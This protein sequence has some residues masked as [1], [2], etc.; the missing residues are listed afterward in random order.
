M[1]I[2]GDCLKLPG[3]DKEKEEEEVEAAPGSPGD[4]DKTGDAQKTEGADNDAQI[5]Q[6]VIKTEKIV[7]DLGIKGAKA[8]S[9]D[10]EAIPNE[11][12]KQEK[13]DTVD[14]D[15]MEVEN[16]DNRAEKRKKYRTAWPLV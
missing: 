8:E 14:A 16:D 2:Q 1:G 13:S 4:S 10:A 11:M 7:D 6:D 9:I 3:A 15:K 5:E 12:G